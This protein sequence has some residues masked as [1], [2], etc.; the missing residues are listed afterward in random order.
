LIDVI[1]MAVKLCLG[2]TGL[3]YDLGEGVS[4]FT[5]DEFDFDYLDVSKAPVVV[6]VPRVGRY[7]VVWYNLC[8]VDWFRDDIKS[9]RFKK[10]FYEMIRRM[11]VCY[12]CYRLIESTQNIQ[13]EAKW[14]VASQFK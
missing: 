2:V 9:E 1:S 4:V 5:S 6:T 7:F 8:C 11:D 3:R 12:C 14:K 13:V 10:D